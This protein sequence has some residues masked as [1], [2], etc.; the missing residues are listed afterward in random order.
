MACLFDNEEVG[1]NTKQGADSLVLNNL[2]H[3]IYTK[4]GLTEEALY[5][6]M[7]NGFMLSVDVAHALHPNY[8]DKC[9]ITNKPKLGQGQ[10]C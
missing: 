9:D 8:T 2:L 4:L 1:S 5:E 7:A 6:D 10:W 3:R